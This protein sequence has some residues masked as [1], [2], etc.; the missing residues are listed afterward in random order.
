VFLFFIEHLS[1]TF[2]ILRIQQ[3]IITNVHR[4]SRK[5]V[6]TGQILMKFEFS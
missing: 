4:S 3:E 1:E 5:A 2:L 6:V